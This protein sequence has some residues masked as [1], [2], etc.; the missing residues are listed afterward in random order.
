MRTIGFISA[1]M[2]ET[3]TPRVHN[4]NNRLFTFDSGHGITFEEA[5]RAVPAPAKPP[6]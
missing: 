2:T 3:P 6:P 1:P 5:A 4:M